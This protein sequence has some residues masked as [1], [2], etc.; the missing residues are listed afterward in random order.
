MKYTVKT[1]NWNGNRV[2]SW[3]LCVIAQLT[4]ANCYKSDYDHDHK[5]LLTTD[6]AFNAWVT[7]ALFMA[8][9]PLS[10]GWTYI[11]RGSS[12]VDGTYKAI[13]L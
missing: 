6:N 3:A 11:V 7:W 10:G 4:G 5:Y 2:V 13:Y 9:R 1:R 8:L 12:M